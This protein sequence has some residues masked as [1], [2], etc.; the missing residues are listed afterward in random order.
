MTAESI[1]LPIFSSRAEAEHHF[2]D[3]CA[4]HPGLIVLPEQTMF[5]TMT[6]TDGQGGY[7]TGYRHV[8]RV[9]RPDVE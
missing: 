5:Q 2:R 8:V 1:A 4:E 7:R 6:I 3:W 9:A